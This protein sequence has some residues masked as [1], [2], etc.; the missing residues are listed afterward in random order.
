[1]NTFSAIP[2]PQNQ[3]P[4]RTGIGSPEASAVPLSFKKQ[5]SSGNATVTA[6]P[7]SMPCNTRR[8]LSAFSRRIPFTWSLLSWRRRVPSA[9]QVLRGAVR[10]RVRRTAGTD[11]NK[12]VAE[13]DRPQKIRQ[14]VAFFGEPLVQIRQHD[15]AASLVE[16]ADGIAIEPLHQARGDLRVIVQGLR[17]TPPDS[18]SPC[19][20][21]CRWHR[22]VHHSPSDETRRRHRSSRATARSDR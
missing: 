11:L 20:P 18:R 9:F 22:S 10:R 12:R 4:K 15:L 13:C 2:R 3:V 19:H 17:Q 7:S 6:P 16:A 14:A 8:R 21:G 1:M 5:S